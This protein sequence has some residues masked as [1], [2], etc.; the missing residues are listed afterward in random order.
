M[1]KYAFTGAYTPETWARWIANPE[2]R[3]AAVSRLAEQAGGK[4][5][6]MYWTFGQDDFLVIIE[7]P[8]DN[9]A[10]A[11]SIAAGASGA[12]QNT[13]TIK[14]IT[15]DDIQTIL[16]KAKS[17]AGAYVPPGAREAVGVR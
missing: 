11:V 17:A 14:L 8:D 16:S 4:L 1:P 15:A 7:A 12:L 10:A 3:R 13:R 2:D 5:D 6:S 9:A